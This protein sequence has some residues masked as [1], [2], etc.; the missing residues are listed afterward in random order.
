MPDKPFDKNAWK[1]QWKLELP[2][3]DNF[4]EIHN[5]LRAE[6]KN[7]WERSLPFAD[8]LFDRWERA[9]FLGFGENTSVYDSAVIMGQV[10]V[11]HDVWI[12][13]YTI[14]DGTGG[15]EIG[16]FVTISSG[17]Q[18][19][20]HSS[21]MKCLTS[22]RA[23]LSKRPISI[24]HST[25]VGSS[26]IV[27]MGVTL[28]S[29]VVVAAKSFVNKSFGDFAIVAGCPAKKIGEV[30]LSDDGSEAVLRYDR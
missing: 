20:S 15:L 19:Y 25:Y 8:E 14:L 24:G 5:L 26:S 23:P 30:E 29:H 10:T 9:S 12:G 28:G 7:R 16:D 6:N 2:G 3:H 17:V 27:N 21:L 13:P 22:G 4:L 11:G 18:I 1:D